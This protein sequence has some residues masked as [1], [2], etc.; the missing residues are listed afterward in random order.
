[1]ITLNDLRLGV[2]ARISSSEFAR[3]RGCSSSTT[4]RER[5]ENRSIPYEKDPVTGRVW[6]DAQ[7]VLDYF[8]R[9]KVTCTAQY[10]H[11]GISRMALARE[12]KAKKQADM[13]AKLQVS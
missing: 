9:T 8:D 6:F 5:W 12:A 1:M 11:Y 2:R 3:L 4:S 7:D 13:K 10:S